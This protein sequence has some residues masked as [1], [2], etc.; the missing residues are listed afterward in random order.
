[1]EEFPLF[2]YFTVQSNVLCVGGGEGG[3]GSLYFF[4]DLQSFELAMQDSHQV[5]I[6]LKPDTICTFLIHYGT[7]QKM[8]TALFNFV[9][10]TEK[11]K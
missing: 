4:S 11:S 8:L 9:W 3:G 2:Y 10:N 5:F 6:V 7:L 1:M